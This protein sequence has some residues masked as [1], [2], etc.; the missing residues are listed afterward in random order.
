[1][2]VLIDMTR[3]DL[4]AVRIESFGH[5]HK[6]HKA[7][8]KEIL[9]RN[10]HDDDNKTPPGKGAK[11]HKTNELKEHS[12]TV[13]SP[14]IHK[15]K[16]INEQEE[17]SIVNEGSECSLCE[18]GKKSPN[19]H[20]CRKCGVPVC[21]FYCSIQDPNSDNEMHRV[22]KDTAK[23]RK[24]DLESMPLDENQE[25]EVA[26]DHLEEEPMPLDENQENEVTRDPLEEAMIKYET[27]LE[28]SRPT[29]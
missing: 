2:D 18:E 7:I 28:F 4:E 27:P 10:S 12:R 14:K 20:L 16:E 29:L 15:E 21:N 5:R 8:Q 11:E 9:E 17:P 23:C 22:H 3:K 24:Q 13:K 19:P 26:R 6:I 1:M 25:N